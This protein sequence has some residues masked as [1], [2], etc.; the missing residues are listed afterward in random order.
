MGLWFGAV[1]IVLHGAAFAAAAAAGLAL[2]AVGRE[3]PND[4]RYE[5]DKNSDNDDIGQAFSPPASI[6]Q[7]RCRGLAQ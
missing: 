7:R 2:A 6:L 1:A 3:L 5:G 4:A